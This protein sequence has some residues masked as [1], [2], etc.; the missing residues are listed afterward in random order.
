M[1]KLLFAFALLGLWILLPDIADAQF[2]KSPY[3]EKIKRGEPL[4]IAL[5]KESPPFCLLD[6][7]GIPHGI[8]VE[9]ANRL[10]YVLNAEIIFVFPEFKDILDRIEDGSIDLAIA[11]MTI[12]VERA[13]RVAFSHSYLDISQG[14]LLDRRYIPRKI[15]EGKVIDVSIKSFDD[16]RKIPGLVYG[17]W[18]NSTSADNVQ[19][20]HPSVNHIIF[21]DI[22]AT[23][24]ALHKGEINIMI[25]DSPIIE[26]ISNHFSQDRKRFKALTRT[27]NIE[28]LAIAMHM[29]DPSFAEFLNEFVDELRVDGHMK[30]WLNQYLDDTS[31]AAE[32]MK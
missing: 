30:K 6:N 13:T 21:S 10:A 19:S 16:L 24:E 7:Q 18:S 15:V 20:R 17:T 3:F 31:W 28:R 11:N 25:A 27:K 5:H 23:R 2:L 1:R 8:D 4:V 29:G 22:T 26:F 14:A 12:T 32:V 9:I